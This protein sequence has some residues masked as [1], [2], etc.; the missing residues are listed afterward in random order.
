VKKTVED[1]RA[2]THDN[3]GQV[4]NCGQGFMRN[5]TKDTIFGAPA[6]SEKNAWNAAKC[7]TGEPTELQL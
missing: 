3:L 6:A 2:V 1:Q 4:K 5:V 7:I